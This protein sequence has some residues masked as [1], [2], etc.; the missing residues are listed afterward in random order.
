MPTLLS[1]D[2]PVW[3]VLK[4]ARLPL[5]A[6][7]VR[8]Y[9]VDPP[10]A[11]LV[12]II[13]GFGVVA[14]DVPSVLKVLLLEAM[15][16]VLF[17]IVHALDD[18]TGVKTGTDLKT[19][20]RKAEIGEP[21]LLASGV[22]SMSEAKSI[23]RALSAVSGVMAF[24]VFAF[25]PP[26]AIVA[27]ILATVI[28]G[29]YSYGARWSYHGLGELTVLLNFAACVIVPYIYI[30]GGLSARI[31]GIGLLVGMSIVCVTFCS[32]FL[33]VEEDTS[34]GRKS[35]MVLLGVRPTKILFTTLVSA[36]WLLYAGSWWRGIV[37]RGAVVVVALL[38]FHALAI[39]C[40]WTDRPLRA[41][42][43]CF[44]GNRLHAVLLAGALWVENLTV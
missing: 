44:Y 19:A 14:P 7:F 31:A 9:I 11:G 4:L 3:R 16:V 40:F 20:R 39:H 29:Q 41:R 15:G 5:Y 1:L 21:K 35:L 32:N 34:T 38:P 8:V 30:T 37:P 27:I 2:T 10:L 18:I 42:K 43:L 24:W 6:R 13:A 12:G 23:V 26:Q 28:T 17:Y 22:L 25:A 36:F 33:D